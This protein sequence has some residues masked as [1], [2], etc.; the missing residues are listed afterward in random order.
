MGPVTTP[1]PDRCCCAAASFEQKTTAWPLDLAY[2][3][4]RTSA[5]SLNRIVGSFCP[6]SLIAASEG[7]WQSHSAGRGASL[8]SKE[9]IHHFLTMPTLLQQ[10]AIESAQNRGMEGPN[11]LRPRVD[12]GRVR[13]FKRGD[14]RFLLL[15]VAQLVDPFEQAV[16]GETVYWK[17]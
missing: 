2:P 7:S 16:L 12:Q 4:S 17:F 11:R 14:G 5:Q 13:R 10:S 9:S 15:D 3:A 1:F 8:Q 6:G